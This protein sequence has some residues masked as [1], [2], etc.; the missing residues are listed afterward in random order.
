RKVPPLVF[1]ST[2][3]SP[4]T[5]SSSSFPRAQQQQC[6]TPNFVLLPLPPL[7]LSPLLIEALHRRFFSPKIVS[8]NGGMNVLFFLCG[9]EKTTLFSLFLS[10][11]LS[12]KT[13]YTT[14][15]LHLSTHFLHPSTYHSIFTTAT[16]TPRTSNAGPTF[17]SVL[18]RTNPRQATH[19]TDYCF[20]AI[21][22]NLLDKLTI[23]DKGLSPTNIP[24]HQDS[25]L[26]TSV[27]AE[28]FKENINLLDRYVPLRVKKC[29]Y[30]PFE[31][32][33]DKSLGVADYFGL[34]KKFHTPAF[35][36][37]PIFGLHN[38][39]TAYCFVTLVDINLKYSPSCALAR[40]HG[41][42]VICPPSWW[43][44]C[45]YFCKNPLEQ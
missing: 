43:C 9:E 12:K 25:H 33:C 32:L 42:V 37:V 28:V 8:N 29:A 2:A 10:L 34:F 14:R 16:P 40:V 22:S 36:G 1:S 35:E 7:N 20:S 5:S 27:I 38:R 41:T 31:E 6:S 30:F 4:F 45:E 17:T 19:F 26:R 21:G 11:Y 24:S 13:T 39:T 18:F 44:V 3:P 15:S 23:K